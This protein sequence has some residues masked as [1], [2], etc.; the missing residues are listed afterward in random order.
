M[1]MT[2]S[3]AFFKTEEIKYSVCW[4]KIDL[5][6]RVGGSVFISH[7][8]AVVG[9][10]QLLGNYWMRGW[11]TGSTREALL[12]SVCQVVGMSSV[13]SLS[14]SWSSD[15]HF[16]HCTNEINETFCRIQSAVNHRQWAFPVK[17]SIFSP[18]SFT[19]TFLCISFLFC[20]VLVP[21]RVSY[22]RI[23]S[24]IFSDIM[25]NNPFFCV[26]YLDFSCGFF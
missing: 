5:P 10:Q 25:G 11:S 22:L 7:L 12:S 16:L 8:T 17:S 14:P 3:S 15:H 19:Y 13:F 20:L 18:C 4:C 26:T 2:L 24:N 6:T 21:V 1:Y 23:V 9:T